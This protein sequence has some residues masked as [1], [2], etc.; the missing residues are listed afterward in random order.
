MH[1]PLLIAFVATLLVTAASH[2][3]VV[4]QLDGLEG[5]VTRMY[6]DDALEH[7]T[8]ARANTITSRAPAPRHGART[9][10]PLDHVAIANSSQ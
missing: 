3:E 6:G 2:R 5:R 8:G 1:R 10:A 9:N 7:E 4:E